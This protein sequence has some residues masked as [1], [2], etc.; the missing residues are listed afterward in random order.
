MILRIAGIWNRVPLEYEAIMLTTALNV[1]MWS[2]EIYWLV[3]R[4]TTIV[5][6]FVDCGFVTPY[7]KILTYTYIYPHPPSK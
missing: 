4:C 7:Y 2:A 5:N 3:C 1:N 6:N